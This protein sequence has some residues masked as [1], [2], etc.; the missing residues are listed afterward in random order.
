MI[1]KFS[2]FSSACPPHRQ[3]TTA[4]AATRSSI[5]QWSRGPLSSSSRPRLQCIYAA[6]SNLAGPTASSNQTRPAAGP[7]RQQRTAVASANAAK[8]KRKEQS[9]SQKKKAKSTSF[10]NHD[11]RKIQQFALCDAMRYVEMEG[12]EKTEHH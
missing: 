7:I 2:T 1:S 9:T 11:V 12:M 10:V 4:M 8:Y 5:L 6:G 3:T